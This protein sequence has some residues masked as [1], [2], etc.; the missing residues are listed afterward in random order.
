MKQKITRRTFI[1]G[2]VAGITATAICGFGFGR[3]VS[4]AQTAVDAAGN[5]RVLTAFFSQ[6]GNTRHVAE[7]I[8]GRVGGEMF[9]IAT[10]KPYVGGDKTLHDIAKLEKKQNFRPALRGPLLDPDQ[11]DT[12]FIGYPC[13]WYTMPMA[14]FAFLEQVDFSG[15]RIVPFTTH[16]GSRWGEGLADMRSLIPQ[17][18]FEEGL[19][20]YGK[21][22]RSASSDKAVRGWLSALGF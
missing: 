17:A 1:K 18:T 21:S 5:A 10:A 22:V 15:K 8:H 4:G 9:Q 20:R 16:G 6:T 2:S 12:I 7:Q 13:W 11:Y 14:V 19:A 3:S